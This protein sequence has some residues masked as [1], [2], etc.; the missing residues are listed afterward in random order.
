MQ[1]KLI[2]TKNKKISRIYFINEFGEYHNELGSAIQKFD[3]AESL[4][5]EMF[6]FNNKRH[7]LDG[8]AYIIYANGLKIN[9]LYFIENIEYTR[10]AYIRM[11]RDLKFNYLNS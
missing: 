5:A 1:R 11:I 8:P 9:E 2:D 6:Y 3:H 10:E 7:R 4:I